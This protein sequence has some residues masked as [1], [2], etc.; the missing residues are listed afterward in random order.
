M[1]DKPRPT[2]RTKTVTNT[3]RNPRPNSRSTSP[4]APRLN[5]NLARRD[6]ATAERL[7]ERRVLP[8]NPLRRIR[9]HCCPGWR[10]DAD[11]TV[12]T[13]AWC[14]EHGDWARVLEVAE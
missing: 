10:R 1:T 12:G 8:D 5:E 11:A 9:V 13:W 4:R 2:R 14:D 3:K 7:A 6:R